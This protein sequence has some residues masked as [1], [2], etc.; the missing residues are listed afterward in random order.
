VALLAILFFSLG[1]LS[2]SKKEGMFGL[3]MLTPKKEEEKKKMMEGLE[4][5][6]KM[7]EKKETKE[8]GVDALKKMFSV[9]N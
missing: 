3:D 6:P 1:Y 2:M 7:E 9:F 8:V 5:K 4:M